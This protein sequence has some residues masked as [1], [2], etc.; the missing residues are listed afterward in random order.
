M[1]ERRVGSGEAEREL[2]SSKILLGVTGGIAA[3][4][5][6]EIVRLLRKRGLDVHAVMTRNAQ[7]FLKPLTLQA[8]S[9]N[10]V[11]TDTF[12]LTNEQ[13]IGHI[14]LVDRCGLLLVAPATANVLGKAASGIADDLLTTMICAAT[15]VPVVFAPSMNVHMYQNPITQENIRKLRQFGYH[16]IEPDAGELACGYEGVGRL[17]D[18]CVIV[19]A[20]LRLLGPKDLG[21]ERILVT[22]GPTQEE[23]DPVRFLTNRSSGKMG[24]AIARAASQRGASVTLVSGPSP[25]V[26]P[27][28]VCF[29]PVKSAEEMRAAV[30][31]AFSDCTAVVMAAAVS[32]YRPA[33]KAAHKIKKHEGPLTL[34]LERT[35]DILLELSRQKGDRVLI[36][37]A[38]ETESLIGHAEEKRK[39]KKLDLIVVNDVSRRDIGFESDNNQVHFIDGQ[40]RVTDLPLQPKEALA[41]RILD[42]IPLIRCSAT[43]AGT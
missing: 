7:E 20:V 13:Q 23:I 18:P 1:G 42:Q 24:Y 3:Y 4:K 21:S 15:R 27:E 5:A 31:N 34:R 10:P 32:D 8:L 26:V 39:K 6:A 19:E 25:C 16:F 33:D 22:A 9:G 40:G 28:R 43:T 37:F 2:G 30:L 17:A 41:H 36:G 38:A 14:R 29:V 12:Q 35:P 11:W